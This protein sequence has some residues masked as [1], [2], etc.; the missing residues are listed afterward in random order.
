MKKNVDM[1]FNLAVFMNYQKLDVS[2]EELFDTLVGFSFR[3]DI[4]MEYKMENPQKIRNL[5]EGNM[6]GLTDMYMDYIFDL[7]EETNERPAI[8]RFLDDG[9]IK[10][11]HTNEGS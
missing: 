7:Q 2:M 1:A 11:R 6:S 4:R 10:I 9:S 5:V 3:G 8:L